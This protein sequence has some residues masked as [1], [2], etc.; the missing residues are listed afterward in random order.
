[1][2]FCDKTGAYVGYDY[3]LGFDIPMQD[4]QSV[5]IPQC[6]A[7]LFHDVGSGVLTQSFLALDD[8]IE[9]TVRPKLEQK[10]D[11]FLIVEETVKLGNVGMVQ[12]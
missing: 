2:T 10:V 4:V 6:L 3:V 8:L 11:I 12:A 9:L 1:M 7:D 5:Q